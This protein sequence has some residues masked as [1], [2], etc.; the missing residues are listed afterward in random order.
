MF[1]L[2][3]SLQNYPR[4]YFHSKTKRGSMQLPSPLGSM[5]GPGLGGFLWAPFSSHDLIS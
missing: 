5:T 3:L 2:R 4:T 1:L